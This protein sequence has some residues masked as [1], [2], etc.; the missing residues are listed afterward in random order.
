MKCPRC[1]REIPIEEYH[2]IL[3]THTHINLPL[4]FT[5]VF[6]LK[7]HEAFHAG[8]ACFISSK[9]KLTFFEKDYHGKHN[10]NRPVLLCSS[11]VDFTNEDHCDD[12]HQQNI[13]LM[14]MK[15]NHFYENQQ[16]SLWIV[17][18][19]ESTRMVDGK[20]Y[21][22]V[23]DELHFHIRLVISN[24]SY[25]IPTNEYKS[26]EAL[27]DILRELLPV[28]SMIKLLNPFLT[29][30]TIDGQL[31]LRCDA[32]NIELI[33]S[34]RIYKCFV[35]DK[36][37][38]LRNRGNQAYIR[39]DTQLAI[40]YYTFAI[41]RIVTMAGTVISNDND[42]ELNLF[43]NAFQ[44]DLAR[45]HSNRSACYLREHLYSSA[46]L[47]SMVVVTA[48]F[49]SQT[50]DEFF[51]KCL[52]RLMCADIG[53]QESTFSLE[54]LFDKLKNLATNFILRSQ[55]E[56]HFHD[57]QSALP[58]L[59]QENQHGEYNLKQMF[60]NESLDQ[61]SFFD[62]HTF[63]FKFYNDS[64]IKKRKH[65]LY[66]KLSIPSGT[67]LLVQDAFAF[68]KSG[69]NDER[70]LL[71]VI[72]K[73]LIMAPTHWEFNRLR[74]MPSIDEWFDNETDAEEDDYETYPN[75]IPWSVLVKSQQKNPFRTK[76]FV[77]WWPEASRFKVAGDITQ[78]S[79]CL[80]FICDKNIFIFSFMPINKNDEIIIANNN[81]INSFL[82]ENQKTFSFLL[83]KKNQI[84]LNEIFDQLKKTQ[85]YFDI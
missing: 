49:F 7:H 12:N 24:W 63:H 47:D 45:L 77:G 23:R 62:I 14:E 15:M 48:H 75:V 85:I 33:L 11:T 44:R 43:Q 8:I 1:N 59:K 55:Y 34:E 79:N 72:E 25:I 80:W 41:N 5:S 69:E 17:T 19:P 39:G 67:L 31:T 81:K 52:Y 18:Q 26:I 78:K 36:L 74:S 30:C 27:S 9:K 22:V 13:S 10:V 83:G 60:N 16:L 6:V 32:P 54:G 4:E 20:I 38:E 84:Q 46:K 82:K 51:L 76:L 68:V 70:R 37:D 2:S 21:M 65:G 35:L 28:D 42:C 56:A 53:L 50:Y 3:K 61:K 40:D 58:R 57:I 73:H 29:T 66:A 64:F 71:N